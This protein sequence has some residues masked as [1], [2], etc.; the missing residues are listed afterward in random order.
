MERIRGAC[1]KGQMKLADVFT[2]FSGGFWW[3][4][5]MMLKISVSRTTVMQKRHPD[6]S[7]HYHK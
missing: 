2:L 1:G 3:A 4:V 5:W 7:S 6:A